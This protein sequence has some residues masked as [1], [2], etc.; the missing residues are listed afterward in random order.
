MMGKGAGWDR[1]EDLGVAGSSGGNS[2]QNRNVSGK[3]RQ[4]DLRGG[5]TRQWGRRAR[6]RRDRGVGPEMRSDPRGPLRPH[7]EPGARGW[8]RGVAQT[9]PLERGS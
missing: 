8:G 7:L 1:W 3:L 5:R 6:F 9:P 4:Q 2:T